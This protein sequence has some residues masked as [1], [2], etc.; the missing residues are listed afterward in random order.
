MYI[1]LAI[2]KD[3][4]KLTSCSFLPV[5][6]LVIL[7]QCNPEIMMHD[8]IRSKEK[9]SREFLCSAYMTVVVFS[10]KISMS[11]FLIVL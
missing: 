8:G 6:C 4:V 1:V 11:N 5:A 2:R 7:L 10:W 9:A 3:G